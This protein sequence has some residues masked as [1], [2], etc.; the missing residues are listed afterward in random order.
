[1]RD[2]SFEVERGEVFCLLGP[3]GAG[4]TTTVEILEGYRA[5][6]GGEVS[7]LGFDPAR[8]ERGMRER[9]GIVLQQ[10][11][12]QQDLS[13]AELLEMYGSYHLHPRPIDE[14]LELVELG[15]KRDERVGR[16]VGRPATP[17]RSRRWRWSATRS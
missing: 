5:R 1:M 14:V 10:C 15:A 4:K 2:V 3:N 17:A 11:G 12:V 13:V 9:V 7:V 6:S 8:G 16:A